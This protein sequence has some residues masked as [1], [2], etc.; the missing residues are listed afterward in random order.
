MARYP[1][2]PMPERPRGTTEDQLKRMYTY[3]W[4]LAETLN[5]IVNT[6]EKEQKKDGTV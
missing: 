2:V 1:E 3:L 6:L 4:Q 5:N